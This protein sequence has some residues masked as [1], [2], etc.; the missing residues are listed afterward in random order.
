MS[1]L[2]C[3][4]NAIYVIILIIVCLFDVTT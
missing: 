3:N 2:Y 1:V 4:N